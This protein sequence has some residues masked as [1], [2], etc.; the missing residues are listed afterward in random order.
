MKTRHTLAL[1][2]AMAITGLLA[3]PTL[4]QEGGGQAADGK[5]VAQT[6][7]VACHGAEG[8]STSPVWPN[9]AGQKKGYLLKQMKDFAS[10]A[11]EDP[12]M[13]PVAQRLDQAQIEA[14]V[15]YYSG[16]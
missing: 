8:I 7:C 10:G 13:A 6:H 9:L 16:L 11:R 12:M 4:A 14:V 2:T 3:Q 1:S 15:S 5:S